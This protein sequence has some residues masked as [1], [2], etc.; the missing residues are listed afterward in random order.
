MSAPAVSGDDM[1]F[2]IIQ[3]ALEHG[4]AARVG[5]LVTANRTPLDTPTFVGVTSRGAVP[6]LTPDVISKHTD[7]RATY[8]ALEDFIEK[9]SKRKSP[10]IFNLPKDGCRPLHAY[11]A[12]PSSTLT[13]LAP[14]RTPAVISQNGNGP[15]HISV[16]TSTGFERVTCEAFCAAIDHVMPDVVV[17]PADIN[18]SST[19]PGT[20]RQVYMVQRTREWLDEFFT[21]LD[22]EEKLKP[23]GIH[24]F[25]PLLPI[26]YPM[27]WEYLKHLAEDHAV[28]LAGLTIYDTKILHDLKNHP[29]LLDLPRLSMEPPESPHEILRQVRLGVDIFASPLLNNVSDAGVA[30]T[31]RFPPSTVGSSGTQPLGID[32][33]SEEHQVSVMPFMEGCGCYACTNHHRA[34]MQHL[35]NAREMLGWTLLQIHNHRVMSDFFKNIRAAIADGTFEEKAAEFTKCYEFELP[36]GTGV[37]PRARGY[38]FKPEVGQPK[39]NKAPWSRL[40]GD[41]TPDQVAAAEAAGLAVTGPAAGGSETPLV[42]EADAAALVKE[43]FAKIDG[44]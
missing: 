22:P 18:F 27:Q 21:H 32:V 41:G 44:A 3:P 39:L 8:M 36:L 40:E 31:F 29:Q 25:A 35:M 9:S 7:I 13:I 1:S 23:S 10:A 14:R 42:P 26:P 2:K 30:M 15:K 34:Y 4:L 33:S 20:K 43:G 12:T 37:R 24:V 19:T 6:H 11:T 16:L 38:H 17:P 5:R 28:R